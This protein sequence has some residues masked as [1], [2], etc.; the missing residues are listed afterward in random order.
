MGRTR[1]AQKLYRKRI[2]LRIGKKV[3][4]EVMLQRSKAIEDHVNQHYLFLPGP[5]SPLSPLVPTSIK[6]SVKVENNPIYRKAMYTRTA[7]KVKP[8]QNRFSSK[9]FRFS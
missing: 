1:L 4:V 8:T 7:L 9:H 5:I 2:T 3:V 6:F